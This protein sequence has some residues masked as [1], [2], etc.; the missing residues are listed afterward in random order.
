M[1]KL[2]M[3]VGILMLFSILFMSST[4][5]HHNMRSD[6]W[7]YLG[8]YYG[9]IYHYKY[10]AR[11]DH[12]H[13]YLAWLRKELPGRDVV[14]ANGFR[15]IR[16]QLVGVDVERRSYCVYESFWVTASGEE[17]GDHEYWDSNWRPIRFEE[18][19]NLVDDLRDKGYT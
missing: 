7:T 19:D 14:P 9:D 10:N 8:E 2:R 15:K 4:D 17:V 6:D 18:L 3:I 16:Y 13:C 12:K 5:A 1:K 11:D